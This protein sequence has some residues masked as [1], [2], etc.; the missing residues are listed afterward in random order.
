MK[1]K[2]YKQIMIM[3]I[4]VLLCSCRKSRY[5]HVIHK[6][7]ITIVHATDMHY[8]SP[9]INDNSPRFIELLLEGDGKMTHYCEQ[10]A[11]AFV[12]DMIRLRPDAVLIGGDISYNGEK[13]SLEDYA[14]KL[15]RIEKRGI[16][17]LVIPGNHDIDYPFAFEYRN[18][19]RTLTERITKEDFVHLFRDF[20]FNE[21]VSRDPQSLSYIYQISDKVYVVAI[22]TSTQNYLQIPF[23]SPDSCEW[24]KTELGKLPRDALVISMTH[25]SL[26]EHYPGVE[27]GSVRTIVNGELLA[28][29]LED[30]GVRL[31]LSGHIHIQDIV[32]D[33]VVTDIATVSMAVLSADYAVIDIY[34]GIRRY[35]TESTDL[36][37]WARQSGDDD[38]NL[39]DYPSYALDFWIRGQSERFRS[40]IYGNDMPEDELRHITEFLTEADAYRFMGKLDEHAG[41]LK[42]REEYTRIV[43]L[44]EEGRAGT[45]NTLLE[46]IDTRSSGRDECTVLLYREE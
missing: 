8:L 3:C 36:A 19:S 21:A 34:D 44:A 25:Q 42:S 46:E 18:D 14:E 13:K 11:E 28:G 9:R 38:V 27:T 2:L 33:G 4:I 20:G 5:G 43:S 15:S 26:V 35:H 40:R 12:E 29:I 41:A 22:D 30:N 1:H 23:L 37:A 16:Q 24:L 39:L 45:Y 10:V 6:Q 7:D 32:T 17:V 31:N